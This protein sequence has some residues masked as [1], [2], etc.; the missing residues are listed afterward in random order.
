VAQGW[1]PN[2]PVLSARKQPK[3]EG[4][5]RQARGKILAALRDADEPLQRQT[6]LAEVA[7]S[8]QAQRALDSL[9]RDG[10]VIAKGGELR[11]PE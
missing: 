7:D 2:R 8:E 1:V 5:D 4:S 3:Y 10:L 6:V 11:L 9:L